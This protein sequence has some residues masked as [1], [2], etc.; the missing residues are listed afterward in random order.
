MRN[1]SRHHHLHNVVLTAVVLLLAAGTLSGC[2]AATV[3]VPSGTAEPVA[4]ATTVPTATP[5]VF[6]SND[7]ALAAATAFYVSYQ[8]MANTI[9][10]EGGAD[11]H[12][13]A[14]FVT[15]TMLPGEIATFDRLAERRVHLVGDISFDS[16]SVQSAD[17][18]LGSVNLYMCLDVSKGEVVGADGLSVAPPDRPLRYPLVVALVQNDANTQLLLEKSEVWSGSDFC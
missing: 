12:R 11:P 3:P 8:G 1:P 4:G 17:L 6:A 2:S 16:M 14:A 15:E 13:I 5:P 9:S 7:E 10:R 18:N